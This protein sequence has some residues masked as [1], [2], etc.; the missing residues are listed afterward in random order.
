M[1]ET[2]DKFISLF[3]E[4]NLVIE[5]KMTRPT[6]PNNS[7][8]TNPR[9]SIADLKKKL[10]RLTKEYKQAQRSFKHN[11]ITRQELFDFEWRIFEIQE[12]LNYLQSQGDNNEI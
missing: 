11:K 9:K 3:S 1:M 5:P 8:N 2:I 4:F 6:K 7:T 10:G 12:D